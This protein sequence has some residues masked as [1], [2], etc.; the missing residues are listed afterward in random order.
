MGKPYL[1]LLRVPGNVLFEWAGNARKRCGNIE[2]EKGTA[3]VDLCFSSED[4]V[5][6]RKQLVHLV[7][8]LLEPSTKCIWN[9]PQD[10]RNLR[11]GPTEGIKTR[12]EIRCSEDVALRKLV[13]KN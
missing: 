7:R 10:K 1:R 3:K 8:L 11:E 4:D 12:V 5:K 9:E 2:I 13:A 6:S